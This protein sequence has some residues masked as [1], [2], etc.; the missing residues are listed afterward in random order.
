M[1]ITIPQFPVGA[2][3]LPRMS[4]DALFLP[5]VEDLRADH[6]QARILIEVHSA[7]PHHCGRAGRDYR[8][9]EW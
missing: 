4:M 2:F 1:E 8:V 6:A 7:A 9:W 3:P 5:I